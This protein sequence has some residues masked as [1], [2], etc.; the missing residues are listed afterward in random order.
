MLRQYFSD[1]T[2]GNSFKR[3]FRFSTINNYSLVIYFNVLRVLFYDFLFTIAAAS[4]LPCSS[5][6]THQPSAIHT[7]NHILLFL[8]EKLELVLAKIG[9]DPFSRQKIFVWTFFGGYLFA[10]L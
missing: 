6:K 3:N 2:N 9:L 10:S 4:V 1:V 5:R 7:I 8:S